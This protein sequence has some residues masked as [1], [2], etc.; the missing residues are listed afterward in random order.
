MQQIL[1]TII[2]YVKTSEISDVISCNISTLITEKDVIIRISEI[3][4]VNVF[5]DPYLNENYMH[6]S[7]LIENIS[8]SSNCDIKIT[9]AKSVT[10][11]SIWVCLSLKIATRLK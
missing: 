10:D 5:Q 2:L 3:S 11:T 7:I 6:G 1:I 4:K 9:N 8:V